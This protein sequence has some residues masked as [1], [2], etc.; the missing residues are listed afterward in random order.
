MKAPPQTEASM[1]ARRA[2]V[3]ARNEA[4]KALRI[5]W[6]WKFAVVKKCKNC[7]NNQRKE[8]IECTVLHCANWPGRT[9][10]MCSA[11]DMR[12]WETVFMADPLN[13][14]IMGE[15]ESDTPTKIVSEKDW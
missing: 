8:I 9:G 11:E 15:I 12:K 7:S 5:H 13:Q 10:H 1:A 4:Q 3:A 6:T 14:E 2:T